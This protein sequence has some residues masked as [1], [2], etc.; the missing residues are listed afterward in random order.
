MCMAC[1]NH[2]YYFT[3]CTTLDLI[4]RIML[5]AIENPHAT[6]CRTQNNKTPVNHIISVSIVSTVSNVCPAIKEFGPLTNDATLAAAT[7][8]MTVEAS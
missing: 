2:M 4:R 8:A 3:L 6:I 1:V 5:P 7:W